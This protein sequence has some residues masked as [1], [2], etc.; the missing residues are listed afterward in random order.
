[1]DM[2]AQAEAASHGDPNRCTWV[3]AYAD[4]EWIGADPKAADELFGP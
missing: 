3:F 4:A 1:M 2:I